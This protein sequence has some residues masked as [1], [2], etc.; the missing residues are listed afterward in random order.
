MFQPYGGGWGDRLVGMLSVIAASIKNNQTWA[1]AAVCKQLVEAFDVDETI[2]FKGDVPPQSAYYAAFSVEA[3]QHAIEMSARGET[4]FVKCNFAL[5]GRD[6]DYF[7]YENV[8]KA[9]E[10]VRKGI[11]ERPVARLKAMLPEQPPLYTYQFR[12]GDGVVVHKKP[13]AP[14]TRSASVEEVSKMSDNPSEI[15]VTSDCA[16]FLELCKQRGMQT[17]CDKPV[18]VSNA[19]FAGHSALKQNEFLPVYADFLHICRTQRHLHHSVSN[20]GIAAALFCPESCVVTWG[21]KTP[22]TFEQRIMNHNKE[23]K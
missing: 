18:H 6:P 10:C 21:R 16:V 20:F 15:F 23:G 13:V 17:L 5:W 7:G 9:I 4:V 22:E 2:M 3:M 1:I 8:L 11:L 12:F 14:S 19:S